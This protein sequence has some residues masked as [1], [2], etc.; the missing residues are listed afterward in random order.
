MVA[1]LTY[2]N[3]SHNALVVSGMVDHGPDEQDEL[4]GG[5]DEEAVVHD[6]VREPV[7][8]E[9]AQPQRVLVQHGKVGRRTRYLNSLCLP[10]CALCSMRGG[11][12]WGC[13]FPFGSQ[14]VNL[15][16]P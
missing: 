6:V 2:E 1:H 4:G 5:E 14:C 9:S 13:H 3:T 15:G 11:G 7:V 12:C 10:V 8:E 16:N